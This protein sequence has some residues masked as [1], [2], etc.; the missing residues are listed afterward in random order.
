MFYSVTVRYKLYY[1]HSLKNLDV[2]KIGSKRKMKNKL[3]KRIIEFIDII[4]YCFSLSWK[5]SHLYT[6][7]RLVEKIITPFLGL[8]TAFIG[9]YIIDI[10]S[11]DNPSGDKKTTLIILVFLLSAVGIISIVLQKVQEYATSMQDD[12]LK[13]DI[14]DKMMN[15]AIQADIEF[16]DNAKFYDSFSAVMYDMNS[17]VFVMWNS[18][19]CLSSFITFLVTFMILCNVNLIYAIIL[20]VVSVPSVIINK[21][22]TEEIYKISLNQIN[23]Q[24]KLNYIYSVTTGKHYAEDIRLFHI[25]DMLKEKYL[26]LWNALYLMR[27]KTIKKKTIFVIFLDSLPQITMLV[28]IL[29]ITINILAGHGTVG[30]YSLYTGILSQLTT[31]IFIMISSVIRI[32]DDKLRI[33]NVKSFEKITNKIK[34]TGKTLLTKI[35]NIEF[36]N[37]SF[38]Y[39]GTNKVVLDNINF[40]IGENMKVALV[41]VNGAGKSTIIKLLLRFYDV[42]SGKILIN[43]IDLRDYELLSLRK[44]FSSCFQSPTIYGFSL[45][46]NIIIGDHNSYR[47]DNNEILN[48]MNESEAI[49]ILDKAPKGLDTYLTRGFE[50]DGIELSGGQYQ[51]IVLARTFYRNSLAIILD[52]PSSSLDPEAEHRIFETLNKLCKNK[53]TLFTSHR[54]SNISIAD[55]IVVIEGGKI[56]EQG[57]HEH[58]M[59]NPNRYAVLYK[60][61]SDKFNI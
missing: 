20:V 7:L 6:S 61:Q 18:I 16:F 27:R 24:R 40:T 32:Y 44:A 4:I 56:I 1:K 17:V 52:E 28:I 12:I 51:K 2:L 38:S 29:D 34:N 14:S 11:G 45:K 21:K 59:K 37:V 22:F 9:K 46:E 15:H 42:D 57:T 5:S 30:D 41:G 47:G 36:K 19:T 35:N 8:A 13:K 31:S 39:P 58:L 10:I 50:S 53:T 33:N 48:A 54:L 49:D 3:L 26:N 25:G 60:Y 43:G 55:K 23:D